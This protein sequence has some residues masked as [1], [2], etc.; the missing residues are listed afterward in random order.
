MR[1]FRK[2]R[3]ADA[4]KVTD[5]RTP[6]RP[7]VSPPPAAVASADALPISYTY[8][9]DLLLLS[10][11]S[12]RAAVAIR[13]TALELI[14]HHVSRGRRSL[15]LCGVARGA[16]VSFLSINLAL[17]LAMD[18]VST[19]VIDADLDQPSLE[20]FIQP[21]HET[22]GLREYLLDPEVT[23]SDVIHRD[24]VANLSVIYAGGPSE[25]ASELIG[26]ARFADLV[27]ACMRDHDLVIIDT[28]PASLSASTR[29]I[30]AVA[31]YALVVAR[32]GAS[33][34]DGVEVL[35]RSLKDDGVEIV[36]S[37]LNAV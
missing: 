26:Q 22:A 6:A 30:A 18:G 17:A 9:P 25:I 20:T 8:G 31:H 37:V 21:S 36:G 24:V 7:S 11:A 28:P 14:A 23:S 2:R 3:S 13:Q 19:L 32:S 12:S 4:Q 33:H 29:R 35:S 15:A 27:R 1:L 16:G 10:S 34:V 5:N